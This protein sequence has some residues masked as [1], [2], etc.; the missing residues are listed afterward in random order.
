MGTL[1]LEGVLRPRI[2][3]RIV[4]QPGLGS[5]ADGKHEQERQETPVESE[6]A[7]PAGNAPGPLE[8]AQ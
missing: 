7:D 5:E 3:L 8:S 6:V 1:M 4:L 2:V